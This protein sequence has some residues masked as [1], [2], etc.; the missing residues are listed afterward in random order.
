MIHDKGV[1]ANELAK[2]K[3]QLIAD[4]VRGREDNDGKASAIENAVGYKQDPKDVNSTVQTLQAV[5]AA[6]I[7]RVM[8]KYF[9]DNNRV[10]IYYTNDG[11]TK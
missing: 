1:T 8:K 4:A 2:A 6:D 3:N 10:V 5:T 7:Q 11:G 9:N